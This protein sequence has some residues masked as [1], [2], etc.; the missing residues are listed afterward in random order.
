MSFPRIIDFDEVDT[1]PSELLDLLDEQA[2]DVRS[3]SIK[4]A[5]TRTPE[6]VIARAYPRIMQQI[7]LLWGTHD[8]QHRF[9]NW[10]LTDQEGRQGWPVDVSMALIE[11][12]DRHARTFGFEATPRWGGKPDRW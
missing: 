4:S 3:S 11:L 1:V 12:E 2:R 7:K 8:L 6:E 5:P 10:L 9:T